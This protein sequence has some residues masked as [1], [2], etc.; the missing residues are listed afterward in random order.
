MKRGLVLWISGRDKPNDHLA[1]R[2][3][4]RGLVDADEIWTSA[5]PRMSLG[6]TGRL[7]VSGI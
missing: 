6:E 7:N 3:G 4:W 5:R 2:S 1:N